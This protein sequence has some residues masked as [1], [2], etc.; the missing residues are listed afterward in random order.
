MARGR[1]LLLV[2]WTGLLG[3]CRPQLPAVVEYPFYAYRNS[4]SLELLRVERTDTA[5]VLSMRGY[6]R[7]GWWITIDSL[8]F[9][10]ADGR[11][12]ALHGAEGI[13]PGRHLY[14]REAETPGEGSVAFRLFFDPLPERSA[15]CDFLEGE[16]GGAFNILGIDLTGRPVQIAA[17]AEGGPA[18]ERLPAASREPGTTT[19]R[20]HIPV[21]GPWT[22]TIAGTALVEGRRPGVFRQLPVSFDRDGVAEISFQQA[23]TSAARISLGAGTIQLSCWT[24]PGE[25]ADVYWVPNSRFLTIQRLDL[26]EAEVPHIRYEGAY[27][28]VNAQYGQFPAYR[29]DLSAPDLFRGVRTGAEFS[30]RVERRYAALRARL[31]ADTALTPLQ[32]NLSEVLLKGD[33]LRAMC[34]AEDILRLQYALEHGTDAG[35]SP[36]VLTDADFAWL[37]ALDLSDSHLLFCDATEHLADPRIRRLT[38]SE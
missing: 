20:I 8:S 22:E 4:L 37:S 1:I 18:P 33:V 19:L 14:I 11:R 17:G 5:T 31:D 35:Y 27:A 38:D 30:A 15:R 16:S 12:C 10:Y 3:A 21:E 32:R 13:V 29:L 23:R 28:A 6:Y 7:P 36:V 9:L 24:E 34:T 25:T 2:V 26:Q